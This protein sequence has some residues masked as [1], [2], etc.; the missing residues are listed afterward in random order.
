[1]GQDLVVLDDGSSTSADG[2]NS[3]CSDAGCLFGGLSMYQQ[4][5]RSMVSK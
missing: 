3:V 4:D 2:R 1:M 5:R